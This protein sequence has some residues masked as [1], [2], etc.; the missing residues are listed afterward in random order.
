MKKKKNDKEI[1]I[2]DWEKNYDLKIKK[3]IITLRCG[4]SKKFNIIKQTTIPYS[5]NNNIEV[6]TA[7]TIIV[8]TGK[9]I[10]NIKLSLKKKTEKHQQKSK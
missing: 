5:K 6:L 4:P 1:K 10:K 9:T 7:N 2:I 3:K 8:V